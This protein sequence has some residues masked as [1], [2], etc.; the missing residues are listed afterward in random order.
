MTGRLRVPVDAYMLLERDGKLLMLR[1]APGAAYAAGLLCPP[2]GHVDEGETVS[3]AAIREAA[4]ETGVDWPRTW[5]GAS[6]W[7]ITAGRAARRASGGSSP[8]P[9]AGMASRS[10][11]SRPSTPSWRGST[12]PTLRRTWSRTRG[13]GCAPG[14]PGLPTPSISR[15][16]AA[17]SAMNPA[18]RMSSPC[19]AD[20]GQRLGRAVMPSL[21]SRAAIQRTR[22]A[23][24]MPGGMSMTFWP[25]LAQVERTT[26]SAADCRSRTLAR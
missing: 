14:R 20:R 4:E 13:P 24:V 3:D 8:P 6:P 12:R 23:V 11:R 18:M 19:W 17:R 21:A 26:R 5:C 9:P 22:S 2:S 1:R 7:C 16:R 25:T 10:T 15:S